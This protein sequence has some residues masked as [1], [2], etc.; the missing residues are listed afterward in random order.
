MKASL[1]HV[2]SSKASLKH[3]VPRPMGPINFEDPYRLNPNGV[4]YTYVG[5]QFNL[6]KFFAHG[7]LPYKKSTTLEESWV[8]VGHGQ[9]YNTCGSV[10]GKKCDNVARHSEGRTFRRYLKNNCHRRECP[11]CYESWGSIEA[12]RSL[13][14]LASYVAGISKVHGIVEDTIVMHRRETSKEIHGSICGTLDKI[15]KKAVHIVVSPAPGIQLDKKSYPKARRKAVKLL[16]LSGV[17]GGDLIF[18]AKR[19]HC[20]KCNS[21]IPDYHFDC[22]ECG[23]KEFVWVYS[24]HWHCVG[25]GWIHNTGDNYRRFG[26]IIKNLGVRKSVYATMQYILSHATYFKDP[27]PEEN[28]NRKPVNFC[29]VTWFGDLAYNQLPAIPKMGMVKELCPHCGLLLQRMEDEELNRFP[30]PVPFDDS[31]DTFTVGD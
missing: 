18:H 25:F 29:I 4:T 22:P 9:P 23:C 15:V 26:W 24:P 5:K 2:F 6:W 10:I 21:E 3:S 27:S 31:L 1:T 30:P 13:I 17:H 20:A 16:R 14:R 12:E 28:S 7:I 19:Y 11:V 8:L